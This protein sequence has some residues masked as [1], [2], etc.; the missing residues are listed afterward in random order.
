M[1]C[2]VRPIIALHGNLGGAADWEALSLPALRAVDLWEQSSLSFHEFASELATSLIE[3]LEKP[4]LAGYSLGG[5]LALHAMARHPERWGGAVILS[6]HPGLCC[7]E[8]R[9]ARRISDEV[10]A[11]DAREMEWGDFLAKWNRQA[12]L[13]GGEPTLSQL[14]LEPQRE[15]VARAFESWSLGRQ[16]DL[17][18]GLSSFHAPVLWIT[19]ERDETFTRLGAEMEAVFTHFRHEVVPGC[20]HRVLREDPEAVIRYIGEFGTASPVRRIS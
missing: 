14:A 9:L 19:G 3:G 16:E 8:E 6:A 5:R 17:R 2:S 10:W 7:V 15:A 11:R 4:L 13:E 18:R 20:G 12:V 1:S